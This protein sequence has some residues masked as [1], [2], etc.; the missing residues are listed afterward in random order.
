LAVIRS[1]C[2][3][4]PQNPVNEIMKNNHLTTLRVTGMGL[5]LLLCML[6]KLGYVK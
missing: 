5:L 2:S 1:Y 3:P 6:S 4:K